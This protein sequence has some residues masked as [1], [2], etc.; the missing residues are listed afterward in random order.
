MISHFVGRLGRHDPEKSPHLFT[1]RETL[2]RQDN[3]AVGAA[4]VQPGGV[5]AKYR[6]ILTRRVVA[7]SDALVRADRIQLLPL[8]YAHPSQRGWHGNRLARHRLVPERDG[9]TQP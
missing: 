1:H 8:P 6:R 2:P 4:R 9:D 3:A 7:A 5:Q